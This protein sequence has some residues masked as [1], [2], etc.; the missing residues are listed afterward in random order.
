MSSGRWGARAEP[1]SERGTMADGMKAFLVAV[2]GTSVVCYWLMS[3]VQNRSA[4]RTS[5]DISDSGG[6]DSGGNSWSV[7]RWFS[8]DNSSSDSSGSLGSSGSWDSG[9]SDSGGGGGD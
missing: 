6:Y 3:R 1:A 2:G 9:G 8:S 4:R 5:G 7:V